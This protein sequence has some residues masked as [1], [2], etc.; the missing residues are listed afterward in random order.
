M[1]EEIAERMVL[2]AAN[3]YEQKYY[4]NE[5]F[6]KLPE[7][8]RRELQIMCVTFTEEAGG[9]LFLEFDEDGALQLRCEWDESDLLYDDIGAGMLVSRL[10]REKRELFESLEMYYKLVIRKEG[11]PEVTGAAG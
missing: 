7:Q 2:C 4:L 10:Q 1:D 8:I 6:S 5:M 11:A 9:I 3:A